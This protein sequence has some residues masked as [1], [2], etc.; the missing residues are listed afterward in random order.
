MGMH[1]TMR[2]SISIMCPLP[3]TALIIHFTRVEFATAKF[4][5]VITLPSSL[6]S[7][8]FWDRWWMKCSSKRPWAVNPLAK[9]IRWNGRL[10]LTRQNSTYR[11]GH[12]WRHLSDWWPWPFFH[13]IALIDWELVYFQPMETLNIFVGV[14]YSNLCISLVMFTSR[15]LACI[16]PIQQKV[17]SI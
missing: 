7:L 17:C 3:R 2:K 16:W 14:H 1:A 10:L 5:D 6:N 8:Q 15:W 12:D 4:G 11:G 13:E 9:T